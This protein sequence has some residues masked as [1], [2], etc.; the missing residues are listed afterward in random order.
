[1]PLGLAVVCA[2]CKNYR[3]GPGAQILG[4]QL[5]DGAGDSQGSL[6]ALLHVTECDTKEIPTRAAWGVEVM[7][8]HASLGKFKV[9][10]SRPAASRASQDEE[11]SFSYDFYIRWGTE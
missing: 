1:M 9:L 3:K 2:V 11:L 4:H 5:L 7:V 8:P 10:F 6:E